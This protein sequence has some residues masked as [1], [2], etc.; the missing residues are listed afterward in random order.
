M[1]TGPDT[2]GP[3][4]SVGW[5][6]RRVLL[7]A[8]GVALAG[9]TG[10]GVAVWRAGRPSDHPW[11]R[12]DDPDVLVMAHAGGKA[13]RPDNT[14]LA[15]D[16]AVDLG[17]DV[18]ET[19]VRVTADGVPVCIHDPTVDGRTDGTGRVSEMTLT[20]L[21]KLDGAYGWRSP[22]D[23]D[24]TYRGQG[25]EVPTLAEAFAAH[26]DIRWNVELKP[27]I[28]SVEPFCRVV[29]AL[30]MGSQV[31][32]AS[33]TP[34]IASIRRHCP[35]L[36]TSTHRDEVLHFLAANRVGLT[37][38]YDAPARVF[39]VPPRRDG[40]RILTSNF[41]DGAHER[42]MDVHAWTINDPGEIQ[43]LAALGVDGI[44]TDRP[45]RALSTLS[46]P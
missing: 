19:D 26:P 42:G 5:N 8:A 45:D 25:I 3:G 10:L 35:E 18:L 21:K 38:T 37:A 36:A 16:H 14:L 6:R 11:F 28:D 34:Q 29:R 27:A 1:P 12:P 41:I 40:I 39:Q 22:T 23:G 2:D 7:G 32:A 46:R 15:F 30:G 20:E 9:T 43:R 31:L 33:F 44:I 13:L 24:A 4:S 17:V